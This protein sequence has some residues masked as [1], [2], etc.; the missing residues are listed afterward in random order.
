MP[1][2]PARIRSWFRSAKSQPLDPGTVV[3]EGEHVFLRTWSGDELWRLQWARVMEV[4][5]GK[6]DELTTDLVYME[7]VLDSAESYLVHEEM[8]GFEG[9]AEQLATRLAGM[10]PYG[11]WRA[12]VVQ[13]AF[14]PSRTLIYT[15]G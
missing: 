4:Y 1:M 14:K 2:V 8:E 15:R 6:R 7:L 10:L 11:D 13:R 12:N 5:A 3:L 9:L